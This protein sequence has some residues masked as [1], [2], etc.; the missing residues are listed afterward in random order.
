MD[1]QPMLDCTPGAYWPLILTYVLPPV[2][3]LLSAT[4]LWVASR[5]RSTSKDAQSTSL[6]VA[7]SL[8]LLPEPLER[9]GSRR[10]V[11]DPRKS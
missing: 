3:A 10:A 2:G 6:G 4:A 8:S 7:D 1:S 11:R 9:R 5:A